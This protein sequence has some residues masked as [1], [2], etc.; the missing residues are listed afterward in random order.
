MVFVVSLLLIGT[1]L[2]EEESEDLESEIQGSLY[3]SQTSITGVGL[4]S[5]YCN[6]NGLNESGGIVLSLKVLRSGSGAY[7][8]NSSELNQNR[9]T[10]DEDEGYTSSNW[11][12]EMIESTRAAQAETNLN[13]P[14][15]FKSKP[16]SL[17][18]KD[19]AL[20][21]NYPG[22]TFMNTQFD[23]AKAFDKDLTIKMY[24]DVEDIDEYNNDEYDDLGIGN[25]F[26]LKASFNGMGH[27][28]MNL[29]NSIRMDE[30]YRGYFTVS[31]KLTADSRK[32]GDNGD[33]DVDLEDYPWLPCCTGGYFD[34]S[35][36]DRRYINRGIFT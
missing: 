36:F 2:A 18:W 16:I 25:S 17:L 28:G 34:M 13:I 7:S 30:D 9:I 6:S 10:L 8:H 27:L 11:K 5:V 24:S 31:K 23:F 14:G 12:M 15:S 26:D 21:A 19:T 35:F 32:K 3:S 22:M 4:T 20:T 1:A 33:Y 29:N